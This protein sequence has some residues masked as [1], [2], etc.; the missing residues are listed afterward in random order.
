MYKMTCEQEAMIRW[1]QH[2]FLEAERNY[3]KAWRKHLAAINLSDRVQNL[4]TCIGNR[5]RTPKSLDDARQ[6]T[7]VVIDF[8]DPARLLGFG[9]DLFGFSEQKE[10]IVAAWV[11]NKRP[12]LRQ[13]CP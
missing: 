9:L 1:T 10:K 3:A 6:M 12:P 8:I 4:K 5:W 11:K 2:R 13:C 7:D